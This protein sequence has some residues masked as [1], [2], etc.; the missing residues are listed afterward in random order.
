MILVRDIAEKA[1][2]ACW[3]TKELF[4]PS[5]NLEATYLICLL[6]FIKTRSFS[7]FCDLWLFKVPGQKT[8]S[9]LASA[10]QRFLLWLTAPA[11]IFQFLHVI[12]WIVFAGFILV[13]FDLFS[14]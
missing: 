13:L 14:L 8:H 3:R 4:S 11:F 7:V 1:T 10:S 12:C 6:A 9:F 5:K 2:L